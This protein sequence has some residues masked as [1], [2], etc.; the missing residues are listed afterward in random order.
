MKLEIDPKRGGKF[1]QREGGRRALGR[2]EEK[3]NGLRR[4]KSKKPLDSPQ[5]YK[6]EGV[7]ERPREKEEKSN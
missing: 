5:N 1:L 2:K 3:M 4:E 6:G 7:A